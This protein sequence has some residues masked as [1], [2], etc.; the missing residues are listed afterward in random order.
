LAE[1]GAVTLVLEIRDSITDAIL[2]RAIDRD[3]IGDD[4]MMKNSNRVT[5]TSEV[6]RV[7]RKWASALRERLDSFSGF[8]N[9]AG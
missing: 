2:V 8:K 7:I 5:N 9:T 6:K 1:I 3:S 4:F